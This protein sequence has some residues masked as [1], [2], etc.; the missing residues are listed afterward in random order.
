LTLKEQRKLALKYIDWIL[1]HWQDIKQAVIAARLD[2]N[3]TVDENIGG[4][5]SSI[6]SD[7]TAR[8]AMISVMPVKNVVLLTGDEVQ[9]PE[10]WLEILEKVLQQCEAKEKEVLEEHYLNHHNVTTTSV[11][12]G[13][14]R[15][16]CFNTVNKIK[17]MA[18][19]LALQKNIIMLL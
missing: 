4:G 16:T 5:R 19:E 17:R 9:Q 8:D 3:T 1:S 18:F 10:T 14:S 11:M 6:T 2:R 13:M 15:A 12:V 7:P